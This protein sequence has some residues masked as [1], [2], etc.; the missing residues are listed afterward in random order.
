MS[1]YPF[2]DFT[3]I[4]PNRTS[5][6]QNTVKKIT[7]HH[8]AGALSVEQCGA[9]FASPQRQASANYGVDAAGRVGMYVEETDR[10]WTSSNAENDN[11]AITIEA[12]ND[13]IGGNWHVSDTTIEK[14]IELCADIC[15]RNGIERLNYTG[16][17]TGNLTMHKMFAATACPGPYL[18]SKFPYIADKVNQK[19]EEGEPMTKEEKAAF[20][21]LAA[22]VDTLIKEND[23]LKKR[24]DQ[25]DKMGVYE[26]A[27]IKWAYNDGNLPS[28]ARETVKKLTGKGYLYG[29]DKNSLELS[30]IMLRLLVILDRAGCFGE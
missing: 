9:G 24:L 30:Y 29:N 14:L 7:I 2:V 17:E 27:A 10:A 8:M 12:A 18:E 28:W 15:R 25:Y 13:E 11:Q 21:K 5:P 19:L 22:N 20:E 26:N 6:R 23:A 1:N 3:Q 16:D 4:S